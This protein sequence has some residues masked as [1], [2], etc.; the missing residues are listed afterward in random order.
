MIKPDTN[1]K[2]RPWAYSMPW[3]SKLKLL[4]SFCN[5]CSL[6]NLAVNSNQ[7]LGV[8]KSYDETFIYEITKNAYL[9]CRHTA[10]ELKNLLALAVALCKRNVKLCS[11]RTFLLCPVTCRPLY[12]SH[13]HHH[14][15]QWIFTNGL[16]RAH[17]MK[18]I[19]RCW[20]NRN[21][22]AASETF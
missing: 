10:L 7:K 2:Y 18:T 9:P 12:S 6:H 15:K 11:R 3:V 16:L 4:H 19:S 1:L 5:R 20:S 17:Y 13:T 22:T 21:N 14:C 8:R